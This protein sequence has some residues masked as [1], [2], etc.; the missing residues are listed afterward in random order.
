[1]ACG[2][3]APVRIGRQVEEK[4]AILSHRV[5]VHVLQ[6]VQGTVLVQ[7]V[8]EPLVRGRHGCIR[9]CRH[10]ASAIRISVAIPRAWRYRAP[11]GV[12]SENKLPVVDTYPQPR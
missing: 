11:N 10:K 7:G 6:V 5:M 1:M 4:I 3:T 12:I 9:L 8:P 2:G